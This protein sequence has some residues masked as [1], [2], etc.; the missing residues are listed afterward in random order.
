MLLDQ[1]LSVV[2]ARAE[3]S[4]VARVLLALAGRFADDPSSD[5]LRRWLLSLGRGLQQSG[6]Q[7]VAGP[8][9]ARAAV[10]FLSAVML[11]ARAPLC[12][13]T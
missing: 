4:Q 6:Q 11:Q 2:G 10:D 5:L 9:T 7:L 12:L 3:P 13:E 1:L 8:K